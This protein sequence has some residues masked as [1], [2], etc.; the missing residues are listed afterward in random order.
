M[1]TITQLQKVAKR[2]TRMK[3]KCQQILDKG[4]RGGKPLEDDQVGS[5]NARIF[6][7]ENGLRLLPYEL[8]N[9]R[10]GLPPFRDATTFRLRRSA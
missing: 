8:A 4:R 6:A 10:I 2:L 3:R 1:K 7:C 9:R 5:Y